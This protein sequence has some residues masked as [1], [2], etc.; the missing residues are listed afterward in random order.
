M[1]DVHHGPLD[2]G[3]GPGLRPDYSHPEAFGYVEDG[4][5]DDAGDLVLELVLEFGYDFQH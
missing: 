4:A 5:H 1:P 3:P 2:P